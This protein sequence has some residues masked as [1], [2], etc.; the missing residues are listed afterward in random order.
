MRIA[1]LGYGK[2]GKTIEEILLDRGHEIVLKADGHHQATKDD[3][4]NI[5]VAIEFSQPNAAYHNISLC[6]DN[7][8]PVVSGTTGWH[9]KMTEI[10]NRCLD[11]GQAFFYASNFSIGVNIFFAMNKRLAELINQYSEYKANIK[12]I[13]HAKK[14]DAPSGTAI[15]LA[16]G[17]MTTQKNYEKWA[18]NEQGEKIINIESERNGETPGTHI[19]TFESDVD[20][21]EIKHES[22]NRIGFALGAVL[23]AEF[24]HGKTGYYGM[25]NLL[26]L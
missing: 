7:H 16:E 5:D 6:F 14:V 4:K 9:D 11:E 22:K 19:V 18:L 24:L 26:N 2:M 1:I 3:L 17:I 13:H 8:I 25:T 23:A 15:S 20:K 21:I 10:K 12:E